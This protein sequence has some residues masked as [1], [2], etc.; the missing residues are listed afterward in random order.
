MIIG[1]ERTGTCFLLHE[2]SY[3]DK[4]KR[5]ASVRY[6]GQFHHGGCLLVSSL[7]ASFPNQ[8]QKMK[9]EEKCASAD[10]FFVVVVGFFYI[11]LETN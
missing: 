10:S 4:S 5:L 6:I 9:M 3:G 11:S 7:R 1:T 8:F 2:N